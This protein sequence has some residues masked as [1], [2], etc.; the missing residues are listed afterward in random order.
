MNGGG[1]GFDSGALSEHH[2][3]R[4]GV[5][6][7]PGGVRVSARNRVNRVFTFWVLC[8]FC[9]LSF[10]GK[11]LVDGFKREL[12]ARLA[13]NKSGPKA[14]PAIKATLEDGVNGGVRGFENQAR[15]PSTTRPGA[16]LSCGREA[17]GS[18]R[19]IVVT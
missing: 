11:D 16:G 14:R 19:A 1:R 15:C 3:A 9:T 13:K 8:A 12:E 6:L 17:C 2:P 7:R 18:R 10:L 4:C 5:E